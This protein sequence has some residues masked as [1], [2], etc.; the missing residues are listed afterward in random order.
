LGKVGQLDAEL[1]ADGGFEVTGY[2]TRV[3]RHGHPFMVE[4]VDVSLGV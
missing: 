4:E 1:L 2:D 3:A